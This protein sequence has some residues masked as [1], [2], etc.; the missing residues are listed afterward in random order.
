M[1]AVVVFDLDGTL[2]DSLADLAAAANR[3]LSDQR[4]PALPQET[5][6]G[7]VGNGL[8]KL[9]ERVMTHCALDPE[10][11]SELTQLTLTHY[12][13]GACDRTT[14]YPGVVGALDELRKMGCVLG[15]C[16]N[17]PE[18]PARHVLS[19]LNLLTYFDAVLGGDTLETRKPDPAHL[20]ASFDALPSVG[21]RLFVGDSEV[22]AET[23]QRAQVPFLL[24]ERGYRKSPVSALP[25]TLSYDN[26][27]ALPDLVRQIVQDEALQAR[28]QKD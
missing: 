24:F 17:K 22:D 28:P 7:F 18:A 10:R 23:A 4:L 21:P 20:H 19:E 26:S 6:R 16:T 14:V 25:H 2:I 1:T 3:M 27:A 11:H 9:V 8:P 15:I 13:A 12:N 5:I